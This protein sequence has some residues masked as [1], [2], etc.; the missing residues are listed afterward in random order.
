MS[1]PIATL[2]EVKSVVVK[3][4]G[5][6]ARAESLTADTGLIGNIPEFDS[7][8][9]LQIILALEEHFGI[10]VKDE[11]VTSDL[12]DSLGTLSRFVEQNLE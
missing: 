12:F 3:T 4:L 5:I 10:T 8:A 11:D 6:E 7:M 1:A 2:D 9:V